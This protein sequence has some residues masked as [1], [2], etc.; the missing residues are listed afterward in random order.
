[1][2]V[3][4]SDKPAPGGLIAE[5][6][7]AS[8]EPIEIGHRFVVVAGSLDHPAEALAAET[9]MLRIGEVEQ[10]VTGFFDQPGADGAAPG[11]AFRFDMPRPAT[12]LREAEIDLSIG[13]AVVLSQ[14]VSAVGFRSFMPVAKLERVDPG[15]VR[16]WVFDP[17]LWHGDEAAEALELAVGRHR[18][19]VMLDVER[20]DL[21]FSAARIG[22]AIGFD[23]A[24]A[25]ELGAHGG[26]QLLDDLRSL[27]DV[28]VSLYSLGLNVAS[29]RLELEA[30]SQAIVAATPP[31]AA[32]PSRPSPTSDQP[33]ARAAAP[34]PA[35]AKPA[36]ARQAARAK[37]GPDSIELHLDESL[38]IPGSGV[39]VM[40]WMVDPRKSVRALRVRS[41]RQVSPP[42]DER[43][44]PIDRADVA[45]TVGRKLGM[46]T[47]A[48]GFHAFAPLPGVTGE[49]VTLE[50]ELADGTT[51]QRPLALTRRNSRDAVV[52][53]LS[54]V[55][56]TTGGAARRCAEIFGP[57]IQALGECN[58][59]PAPAMEYVEGESPAA[60]RCSIVVPLYGRL[61]FLQYQAA[62]ASEHDEGLDEYIYVLDEPHRKEEF[63]TLARRVHVQLGLPLRLLVLPHNHGFAGASNAGLAAARGEF[64]CFLNSDVLPTAPGWLGKL[65]GAIE[66]EPTIGAIGPRLLFEDG[67]LQHAGMELQPIDAMGGLDFPRHPGKGRVPPPPGGVRRVP[68]IT[69]ACIVARRTLIEECAGFSTEFVVGDFEDADLCMKL[70]H[71]GFDC[72]IHDG[73]DLYHLERQSQSASANRWRHNLT[74]INAWVFANKWKRP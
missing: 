16:G 58:A 63:L 31:T 57:P 38:L 32:A 21:P 28:R 43:W 45:G 13:G 1:M 9:V 23:V 10:R 5:L 6:V 4:G 66:R 41:G 17:G 62:I 47:L 24:I 8:L 68:M 3:N 60:P 7:R 65:T 72:A 14:Q 51:S 48:H 19:P 35:P 50:V 40:G 54:D 29:A 12:D 37:S 34:A 59:A 2:P 22:R 36:P 74:L 64:V 42:L 20:P 11:A 18:V 25:R 26:R 27:R 61:D 69:G 39:V 71:R 56:V 73:V 53:M 67:T 33:P 49:N 55:K 70:A 44:F 52:R 30:G 15:S 46:E